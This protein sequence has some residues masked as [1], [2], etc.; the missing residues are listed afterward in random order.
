M[1]QLTF[2]P[3]SLETSFGDKS[4]SHRLLTCTI[5][6]CPGQGQVTNGS[7]SWCFKYLSN[8]QS[9]QIRSLWTPIFYHEERKTYFS[10][11]MMISLRFFFG[12]VQNSSGN[13]ISS[14][15][16]TTSTDISKSVIGTSIFFVFTRISKNRKCDSHIPSISR[17]QTY[18][19]IKIR[20]DGKT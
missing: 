13:E 17:N 7:I 3:F 16:C 12:N 11:S 2:G 1:A 18:V 14:Y 4:A 8:F 10:V 9:W 19:L 20:N 15:K 5:G 6:F